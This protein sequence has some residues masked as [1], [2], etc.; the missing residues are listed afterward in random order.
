MVMVKPQV[1]IVQRCIQITSISYNLLLSESD[2]ISVRVHYR[3]RAGWW[4]YIWCLF[5]F[6]TFFLPSVSL[7][8]LFL[9]SP[10]SCLYLMMLIVHFSAL[11]Q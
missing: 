11:S 1:F 2:N 4:C 5:P 3:Q 10:V 7:H 9:P 8:T 6:I